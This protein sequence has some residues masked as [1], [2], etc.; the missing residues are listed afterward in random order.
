MTEASPALTAA[1][2]APDFGGEDLPHSL[3]RQVLRAVLARITAKLGISWVILLVLCAVFAPLVA[4]SHPL[5]MKR[6]GRISSP[7]LKYLTAGDVILQIAFWTAIVVHFFTRATAGV[8]FLIFL[9]VVLV[10]GVAS[11]LLVKAPELVIY[12]QYR[13]AAR[14]GEIEWAIYAPAHYS[15]DDHQRDEEDQRLRPPTR[16]HWFGTTSDAADLFSNMLYVKKK[17]K[18]AEA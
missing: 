16:A 9:A 11:V 6:G 12:E 8:R 18:D 14:A 4:N 13:N 10:A 7:F 5:L 15:P 17:K 2:T 3:F 1:S